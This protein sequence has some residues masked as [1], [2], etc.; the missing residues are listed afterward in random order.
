[1]SLCGVP[2]PFDVW[3]VIASYCE[4]DALHAARLTSKVH[5][6]Y[7]TSN[8]VWD[9]LLKRDFAEKA[10]TDALKDIT[11]QNGNGAKWSKRT[12]RM[13][14]CSPPQPGW[15][16]G[17][18]TIQSMFLYWILTYG[19][20]HLR[21]RPATVEERK[22][23]ACKDCVENGERKECVN[24]SRGCMYCTENGANTECK[25]LSVVVIEKELQLMTIFGEGPTREGKTINVFSSVFDSSAPQSNIFAAV[26][27]PRLCRQFRRGKHHTF[28][29]YGVSGSGKSH[30]L[31]GV[32]GV[33]STGDAAGL[34]PR[35]LAPIFSENNGM[36][37]SIGVVEL[38]DYGFR[39]LLSTSER[40]A[41][42]QLRV[43]RS[44]DNTRPECRNQVFL[45]ARSYAE[46][47]DVIADT[48]GEK[49][50]ALS[51]ASR[52]AGWCHILTIKD[53]DSGGVLR[54]CQLAESY[55]TGVLT[56]TSKANVTL[57][58]I[59][60][61]AEAVRNHERHLQLRDSMLTYL[62]SDVFTGGSSFDFIGNVG[63]SPWY[64]DETRDTI[65]KSMLF[66][67]MGIATRLESLRTLLLPFSSPKQRCNDQTT[68]EE[69]RC[70][71]LA[72]A[73]LVSL[74]L[75]AAD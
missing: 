13:P 60:K 22:G 62:L 8:D 24:T 36:S 50:M 74:R 73:M 51:L 67:T 20:A 64:A 58:S 35:L 9:V 49:A 18:D 38:N 44:A 47:M 12:S 72:S 42:R 37:V 71:S 26:H 11:K 28:I 46:A 5:F 68:S 54:F 10:R 41:D 59:F 70:P 40:S 66:A 7:L 43:K 63:P 31:E 14:H 52:S 2:L 30:T 53:N 15:L 69:R 48:F 29:A 19:R 39:D 57:P 16:D 27:G 4:D 23:C 3:C 65:L 61:A 33:H 56:S 21:V 17:I 6:R 34:C 32:D 75:L 55:K 45:Q 25:N 1:M